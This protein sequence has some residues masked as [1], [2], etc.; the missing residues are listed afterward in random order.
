L[1]DR[2]LRGFVYAWELSSPFLDDFTGCRRPAKG[3]CAGAINDVAPG[4]IEPSAMR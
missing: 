4:Q 3:G 1:N 2:V